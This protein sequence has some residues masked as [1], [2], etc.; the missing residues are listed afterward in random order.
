MAD[1][2]PK[3]EQSESRRPLEAPARGRLVGDREIAPL[4]AVSE[5][6]AARTAFKD[7][8]HHRWFIVQAIFLAGF[9]AALIA[10]LLPN[11]Y[12]STAVLLPSGKSANLGGIARG[13][14]GQLADLGLGGVIQGSDPGESSELF[15]DV[16][17]SRTVGESVLS[18]RY[19]HTAEPGEAPFTL[20]EY[21]DSDYA[22]E[23]LYDLADIRQNP[24]TGIITLSV[25]TQYPHFSQQIAAAFLAELEKFNRERRLT[26]GMEKASF[27]DSR[28]AQVQAELETAENE[29]KDFRSRNMNYAQSS[30][31]EILAELTRL[32]RTST[33]KAEVYALLTQ[34]YELARLEAADQMPIVQ[35]LDSPA[36]PNKKSGPPRKVIVAAAMFLAFAGACVVSV[37]LRPAHRA[38]PESRMLS[39]AS[40]WTQVGPAWRGLK[41]QRGSEERLPPDHG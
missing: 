29:L 34:Q 31:P 40:R 24:K 2:M 23:M 32:E 11:Q 8:W 13:L 36:V 10:L 28:L 30:D 4:P 19:T 1:S 16:L 26:Q 6:Y 12:T 21:F 25:T 18:G 37:G 15:P 33:I 22:F 9:L 17:K 3:R 7:L 41:L 20:Y 39:R 5:A 35:V 38:F 27:L 14:S